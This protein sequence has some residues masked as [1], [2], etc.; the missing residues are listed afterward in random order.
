MILFCSSLFERHPEIK[1]LWKF[2]K[3]LTVQDV[4]DEYGEV[5]SKADHMWKK[6][7]RD[8]G[9]KLFGA[10]NYVINNLQAPDKYQSFLYELGKKHFLYGARKN[11]LPVRILFRMVF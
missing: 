4:H 9:E 7:L 1:H 2:S 3:Y 11:L 10:L 6:Q 8:H 5:I